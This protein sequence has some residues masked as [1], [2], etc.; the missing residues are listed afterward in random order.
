MI[1][2]S[3]G[4]HLLQEG[5]PSMETDEILALFNRHQRI[6]IEYPGMRKDVFPGPQKDGPPQ[7]V[8]FVH[9]A[10]GMNFIAFSHLDPSDADEIIAEQI[11]YFREQNLS[12]SW[13]VYEQD[14]P[15]DLKERLAARG[16]KLYEEEEVMVLDLQSVPASLLE[17]P[18]ADIRTITRPE[19]LEDV[20]Q[21]EEMVW[22]S[23][24]DWARERLGGHLAI[25]GFL[26]IYAAYVEDQPVCAGWVYF[27]PGNPFANLYGG[28]TLA[29]QRGK[30]LYTALLAVRVQEAL[31]RGYRFLT[32][33]AGPMSAPIVRKHGFQLLTRAWDCDWE[34]TPANI[35][36]SP[37]THPST[38]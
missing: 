3:S 33:D 26:N 25:P 16:G 31:R 4:P 14:N 27:H 29:E 15:P 35:H 32:I 22:G 23:N 18:R 24:F 9:P 2:A 10:R 12:F 36:G 30:G 13:P 37:E 21:I 1:L 8:R 19:Q 34:S 5:V 11:A 38:S 20:I 17:S 6:Q 7:L 28:S